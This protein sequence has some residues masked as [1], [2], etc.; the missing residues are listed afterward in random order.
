MRGERATRVGVVRGWPMAGQ[1]RVRGDWSQERA[2]ASGHLCRSM[3]PPAAP[4]PSGTRVGRRASGWMA[5][6]TTALNWSGRQPHDAQR[7]CTIRSQ[8]RVAAL[9]LDSL[10]PKSEPPTETSDS[11]TSAP[12][13][14]PNPT[15][16]PS[17]T[18]RPTSF[19]RAMREWESTMCEPWVRTASDWLP[20]ST[21]A[22]RGE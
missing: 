13:P 1:R 5:Q 21:G 16:R 15:P 2:F 10:C 4:R 14:T 17:A 20:C 8:L 7:T 6:A 9:S 12:T 3:C 19:P 22:E 18:A 11:P